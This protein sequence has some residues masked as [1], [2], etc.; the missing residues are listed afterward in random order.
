MND[1][2]KSRI[3]RNQARSDVI[4]PT[5]R[6][7]L[8]TVAIVAPFGGVVVGQVGTAEATASTLAILGAIGPIAAIAYD[9]NTKPPEPEDVPHN[10]PD[11]RRTDG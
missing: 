6:Y 7:V 9:R 11:E 8:Y 2:G 1:P 4:P 10:Y 5:L 3:R